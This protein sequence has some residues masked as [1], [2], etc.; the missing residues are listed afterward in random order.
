MDLRAQV[1]K[2]SM[3]QGMG[4]RMLIAALALV[5]MMLVLPSRASA[6]KITISLQEAGVNN[7]NITAVTSGNGSAAYIGS[8]GDYILNAVSATGSPILA[9]PGLESSTIDISGTSNGTETL[10][11][12]ITEYGL[13]TPTASFASTFESDGL[14]LGVASLT[15]K[16]FIGD[17][18][19]GTLLSSYTFTDEGIKSVTTNTPSPS[20]TYDETLEYTITTKGVGVVAGSIG[21]AS[22]GTVNAPEPSTLLL[23]GLSLGG[24]LLVSRKR[25]TV[26]A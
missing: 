14:V 3:V 7:G 25:R 5:V 20:G 11:I 8:F 10:N 24:L 16:T 18:G 9:E 19:T 15:E 12:F 17:P 4:L 23:L 1:G 26:L 21:L 13:T 6:D 2:G 22:G